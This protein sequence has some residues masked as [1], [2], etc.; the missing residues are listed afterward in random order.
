MATRERAARGGGPKVRP[1]NRSEGRA[2]AERVA[3][4]EW[5]VEMWG[6]EV[7]RLDADIKRRGRCT[8]NRFE[9]R[10]DRPEVKM[11]YNASAQLAVWE[12]RLGEVGGWGPEGDVVRLVDD[13][14]VD[15][16]M[17]RLRA[18]QAK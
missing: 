12:K 4:S 9:D 17:D 14:A 10:V 11:R 1:E 15:A 3:L 18:E 5:M 2:S 13:A 6:S 16:E 7:K 8:T